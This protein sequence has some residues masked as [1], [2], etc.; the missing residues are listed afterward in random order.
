MNYSKNNRHMKPLY[1]ILVL[2]LVSGISSCN[3]A[4]MDKYPQDKINDQNYW[5]TTSDLKTYANQFYSSL[6]KNGSYGDT[7]DSF[8]G[9]NYSDNQAP[10]SKTGYIWNEYTV[11]T[12]G[13]YWSKGDWSRIR[14][15]NYFLQR[16]RM[17][18]D[19][20]ENINVYVGEI[21]FFKAYDYCQKVTRFGDVPWL[22]EDL[23]TSSEELYSP[24]TPRVEVVDSIVS[25]LDKA[26]AYLPETSSE[27]RLTKY[28][29]LALKSRICLFEGTFR[30]Y[31]NLGDY[32][33][34]LRQSENASRQLMDSGLFELYTTGDPEEDLHAFFQLQNMAGVKEAIFYVHYETDLRRHNVTRSVRESGTGFTKDFAESFLCRTDGLPIALS[35]DYKGDAA[36]MDE[37]ENRDYR[38]KQS[39][40]T[41]DRPI[42]ITETGDMEYENS[43]IFSSQLSSGYRLYK[44]YSPLASDNEFSKCTIDDCLF[45]FGEVLLNYAEVKAELGECDQAVLDQTINKLRDRVAMPHIQYP[46]PFVDPAWPAWEM[47]V[48]PLINEIRRE[49]RVELA[50]EGFRWYD[51]CRWKAGK[52]LENTKTYLGARDP[53]TAAYSVLYPGFTRVWNDKLYLYPLPTDE[54]NY[55]PKLVQNPGW[56]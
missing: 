21:L 44:L 55:N 3:D 10:R 47:P 34:V 46:I 19:T 6:Y 5:K 13:S 17:V 4:F 33:S 42:F 11:P 20:P 25:C 29:A 54:L 31:H 39:I 15:L 45:R 36:F 2:I 52:L 27:G 48:S 12:S 26:A 53:E 40:Y 18:D 32:E 50:C 1:I 49:R 51:L 35:A 24:R 9:D 28:T 37:F 41:P 22:T 30:K 8:F 7:W 14:S 43:P 23:T 38:M 16:Y 56:E